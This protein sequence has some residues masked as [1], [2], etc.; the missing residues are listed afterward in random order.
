MNLV[1]DAKL[2]GRGGGIL[3]MPVEGFDTYVRHE[4]PEFGEKE[5]SMY[6]NNKYTQ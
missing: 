1:L 5:D 4:W 3:N 6:L 2:L